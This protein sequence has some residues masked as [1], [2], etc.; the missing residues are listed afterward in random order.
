[1]NRASCEKSK[2]EVNPKSSSDP[3]NSVVVP[4]VIQHETKMC[5]DHDMSYEHCREGKRSAVPGYGPDMG[6]AM[7]L[8]RVRSTSAM[9]ENP[10]CH[11]LSRHMARDCR[12][13]SQI[14]ASRNVKRNRSGSEIR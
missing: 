3:V 14:S 12:V 7:L 10:L 1:M 6:S 4:F 11:L 9:A 2:S 8:L 5:I 13:G